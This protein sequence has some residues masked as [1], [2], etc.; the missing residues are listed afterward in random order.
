M[1]AISWSH[2]CQPHVR[3]VDCA[4][5]VCLGL[6]GAMCSAG[7]DCAPS[8]GLVIAAAILAYAL[9]ISGFVYDMVKVPAAVGHTIDAKGACSLQN[10]IMLVAMGTQVRRC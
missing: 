3:G 6:R 10:Q 4:V 2:K 7:W 1:E 5:Y 9:L 8:R